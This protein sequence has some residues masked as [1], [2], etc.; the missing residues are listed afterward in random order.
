MSVCPMIN[1]IKIFP[2]IKQFYE[3]TLKD[4]SIIIENK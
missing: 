1:D 4:I 3:E 2:I